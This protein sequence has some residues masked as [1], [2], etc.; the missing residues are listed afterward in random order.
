[1]I[2]DCVKYMRYMVEAFIK[3]LLIRYFE[4][5]K[6]EVGSHNKGALLAR[7]VGKYFGFSLKLEG[8]N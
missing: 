2:L 3:K 1:M 5:S 4:G 6:V 7:R 8:H